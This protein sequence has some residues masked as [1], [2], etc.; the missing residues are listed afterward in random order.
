MYRCEANSV[1]GF[2]QQLAVAYVHHGYFFY[3]T[4]TIPE[5]KDPKGVDANIVSKYGL[6]ITRWTRARRKALGE[7]GLQYIRYRREFVV[8]ATDVHHELLMQEKDLMDIRREPI[9]LFGYSIGYRRARH[10]QGER[11]FR[12]N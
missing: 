6:N 2:V 9:K 11:A 7:V 1:A 3:F 10:I 12:G 8:L 5:R 4:G